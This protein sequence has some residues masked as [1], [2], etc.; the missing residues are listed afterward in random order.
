MGELMAEHGPDVWRQPFAERVYEG[1]ERGKFWADE[2][3][4]LAA[5][6][7]VTVNTARSVGGDAATAMVHTHGVTPE[8]AASVARDVPTL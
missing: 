6:I 4:G 1:V 7:L 5:Q 2:V 3:L 8:I